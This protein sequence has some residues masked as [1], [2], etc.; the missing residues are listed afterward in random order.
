MRRT[1]LALAALSLAVAV[2]SALS[3]AGSWASLSPAPAQ[4]EAQPLPM[5]EPVA[6]A[7]DTS[8]PWLL[9]VDR[10]GE[11]GESDVADYDLSLGDCLDAMNATPHHLHPACERDKA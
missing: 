4:T 2:G 7:P 3:P 1:V 5:G 9:I 6:Y 10:V 11:P 8:G